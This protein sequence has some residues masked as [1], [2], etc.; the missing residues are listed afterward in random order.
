MLNMATQLEK[1]EAE[2]DLTQ[3]IVHV[4]MDAF[5]ANVELLDDPSLAGKPF[6][7]SIIS[8]SS[9]TVSLVES[10]WPRRGLHRVLRSPQ[11][12]CTLRD[13]RYGAHQTFELPR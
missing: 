6:A 8:L 7:V 5:Y 10:G 1:M 13:G 12:W 9:S 11:A 3:L 2:R 4:D